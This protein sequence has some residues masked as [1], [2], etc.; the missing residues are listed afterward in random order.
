MSERTIRLLMI[1]DNEAQRRLLV[2][3]LA[4]SSAGS[5]TITCA[6]R[7]ADG[8]GLIGE[9]GADV[10]LLDLSL[11]DVQGLD[12]LLAL[13]CQFPELPVVVLTGC[14]DQ[15]IAVEA[16]KLGA[17]DYL[18]KGQVTGG[19]L[20]RSLRHAIERKSSEERIRQLN[21]ERERRILE[22]ASANRALDTL[23]RQ[24]AGARDQALKAASFKTDFVA[25]VSHE[26]RTP[27]STITGMIELL[28]KT[29]LSSEQ[30]EF[31]DTIAQA[32][33]SLLETI[34]SILDLSNMEAGKLELD[35]ID[36]APVTLVE[37]TAETHARAAND[38]G[39]CLL[40]FVDPALPPLLS[41]DPVRL[42]QIISNLTAN[43]LQYT[44]SGAVSV[45]AH[46]HSASHSH[47]TVRFA[48]SDTGIGLSETQR[49]QL[50]EPVISTDGMRVRKY[51]GPGLG[52]SICK[53]L[54]DLMGGQIGV[55]S[56][57]GD[58]ATFWF[59]VRLR[60]SASVSGP[61]S[62]LLAAS[63]SRLR[64]QRLLIADDFPSS[65]QIF[66]AYAVASGMET[67]RAVAATDAIESLRQALADGRPY[68]AVL[69]SL[70][71]AQ[72]LVLAE[73]MKEEPLLA[74]CGLV[75]VRPP[76]GMVSP[77][78][79]AGFEVCSIGR[80]V[81]Q[82]EFVDSIE[83][84]LAER[85]GQERVPAQA[86][87]GE[88]EAGLEFVLLCED[89]PALQ[90][91]VSLQLRNL[92]FQCDVAASGVEAVRLFQGRPYSLVLMDCRMP[93]MDGLETT[94]RI[95]AWE[96][97]TGCLATPIVAMTAG[98][99]P[100]DRDDCLASGMDDYMAKP[101][102]LDSLSAMLRKWRPPACGQEACPQA[103][104]P[105]GA[106]GAAAASDGEASIDMV[107]LREMY[108]GVDI[109]EII[110][111]FLQEAG[112]L[113]AAMSVSFARRDGSELARLAHQLAGVAASV[114]AD[115]MRLLGLKVERDARAGRW[116]EMSSVLKSLSQSLAHM[117]RNRPDRV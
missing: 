74:T 32:S 33:L 42:R 39:L 23:T 99:M 30:R 28:L 77:A 117:K 72:L 53:R 51:A 65:A 105:G 7:L 59:V 85:G 5:F 113:I 94:R 103:E 111:L 69:A 63:R 52:L 82:S 50:F 79:A 43:A 93:G 21:E 3:M 26:V 61:G 71:G 97:E 29:G 55:E 56:E 8:I 91:L 88:P 13:H 70:D 12:S 31:A 44:A 87:P 76:A 81:R 115:D 83:R 37:D 38:K 114:A 75:V 19:V 10:V 27:L 106:P 110:P 2:E 9:Q 107:K 66:E 102:K 62:S 68:G 47:V 90:R 45:Q 78:E 64:G 15:D 24:L 57:Q 18:V 92:G 86:A 35:D 20:A 49:K 22:L 116:H 17:Q 108:A 54:V 46:L 1:E 96:K 98:A 109:G 11:P 101:V 36:F 34:N 25:R 80:P 73:K 16:V 67:Q 104:V 40:T 100:G 60:R 6:G 89:D 58:G 84:A 112:E 41:G 48:V 95:R 4:G 14:D